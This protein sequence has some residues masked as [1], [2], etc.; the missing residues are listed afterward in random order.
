[1]PPPMPPAQTRVVWQQRRATDWKREHQSWLQRGGYHGY[2]IPP[3][4]FRS[5][6]GRTHYFRIYHQPVTMFGGN[7]RFQYNGYWFTM[8]DPWPEYWSNNW[9]ETDDVYVD[10]VDGGYYLFNRSRPGDRVAVVV[11]E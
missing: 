9:Y 1:M 11:Y 7:P 2:V 10:Y 3:E 5:S 8:A 4:R 6:F